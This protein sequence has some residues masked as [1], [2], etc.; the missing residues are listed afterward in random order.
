MHVTNFC[1]I[2]EAVA[3]NSQID[4]AICGPLAVKHIILTH[5]NISPEY[6]IINHFIKPSL[7]QCYLLMILVK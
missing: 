4:G 2:Y 3:V 5:K 1:Q 6:V 7:E